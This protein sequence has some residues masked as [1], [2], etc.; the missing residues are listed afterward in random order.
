MNIKLFTIVF[1]G[2][3]GLIIVSAV[4]GNILE[5]KGILTKEMI[6]PKGVTAVL[7][8]YFIL[9]CIMAFSLIPLALRFFLNMQVKIS[10]GEF[11]LIRWLQTHEQ[12]VVYGFW[13][14]IIIGLIIIFSLVKP[15]EMFE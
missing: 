13:G 9:F 14:L 2:S 4:I 5:E 10:N 11:V 15:S 3:L 12:S 6:G 7:S 1:L 8:F